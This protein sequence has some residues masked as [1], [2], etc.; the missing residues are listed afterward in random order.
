MGGQTLGGSR[1]HYWSPPMFD[2]HSTIKS[3]RPL[4]R[5]SSKHALGLVITM[6]HPDQSPTHSYQ[7]NNQDPR[8]SG[9]GLV[10][11][12]N[13]RGTTL[14]L[15][16]STGVPKAAQPPNIRPMKTKCFTITHWLT[17][18]YGPPHTGN[19]APFI[20]LERTYKAQM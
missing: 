13:Q 5:S 8:T 2:H 16:T 6:T 7:T 3:R 19:K 11:Q 10:N 15:A 4:P 17:T 1:V 9:T 18:K 14:P 12:R 20:Q